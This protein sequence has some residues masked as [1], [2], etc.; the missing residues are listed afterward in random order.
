MK[1]H[2]PGET[3]RVMRGAS[4]REENK[5]KRQGGDEFP[6]MCLVLLFAWSTA[7]TKQPLTGQPM[8]E[9]SVFLFLRFSHGWSLEQE[10]S[11]LGE[12]RCLCFAT[13][14]NFPP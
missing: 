5:T 14:P 11:L 6:L 10:S 4:D 8:V 2:R 12:Y 3:T 1:S 7:L 13:R 9:I